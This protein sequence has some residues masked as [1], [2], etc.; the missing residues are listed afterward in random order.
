MIASNIP[1]LGVT[2][3]APG[4]VKPGDVFNFMRYDANQFGLRQ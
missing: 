2:L 4:M 3:S 1:R